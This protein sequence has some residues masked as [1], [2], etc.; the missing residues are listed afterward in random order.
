MV[1]GRLRAG[2]HS[3]IGCCVLMFACTLIGCGGSASTLDPAGQGASDVAW[4]A[5]LMLA[6]TVLLMIVMSALWLHASHS[7][8]AEPLDWSEKRILIGG[9]L[10]LPLA[11]IVLL[12]IFGVRTGQSMLA[13]G[14]PDLQVRATGHQWWWQ[15][16]YTGPNGQIVQVIDALH[17]PVGARVDVL[18]ESADVIHSFWVPS[19]GGKLDAIPGRTNTLRLLPTRTG[20]FAGQCAEFCGARHAHMRFEVTVHEADGFAIWLAGAAES[21]GNGR[22]GESAP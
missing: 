18:V 8:R 14:T 5:W 19:L 22:T 4:I 21:A 6:G 11:V 1:K 15:F 12:L 2:R 10:V 20:R 9:G 17:L 13:A 7:G 16:E 3:I